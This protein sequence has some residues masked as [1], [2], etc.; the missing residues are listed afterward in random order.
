MANYYYY[1][2][3][4]FVIIPKE[5]SVNKFF[6]FNDG[7][8]IIVD[9][10]VLTNRISIRHFFENL[11]NSFQPIIQPSP[12][13]F[14]IISNNSK[15][16]I[17]QHFNSLIFNSSIWIWFIDMNGLKSDIDIIKKSIQFNI[18]N[19]SKSNAKEFIDYNLRL[20]NQNYLENSE[21]G[22]SFNVTPHIY[23]DELEKR[24]E[25]K[26]FD[27]LS[28][29]FRMVEGKKLVA[30]LKM[31]ILLID[32]KINKECKAELVREIL[33]LKFEINEDKVKEEKEFQNQVCWYTPNEQE[34]S[35]III[36]K[37]KH[38]SKN[39]THQIIKN[40]SKEK[41][42][43][44]A[45][46]SLKLAREL[47][48]DDR[49][50]F[51]LV[52]MDYLLDS[53]TKR[54]NDIDERE[55]ATEFWG[56]GSEKFFEFSEKGKNDSKYNDLIITYKK[57][58]ENRGPL[59]KLWIFPI[60]AFNQT[61]IDDLRNKGVRLIDYYWY[62]SRGA[63]PINTPYLFIYTLN[64]FLQLQLQQAVFSVNTIVKFLTKSAENVKEINNKED[65]QAFMG[66]EYSVLIQKHGW[67]P[68]IFRD[69]KA[70]S[71][72]SE[73]IWKEFYSKKENKDLFR[74]LDIVQK[75]YQ[76]CAYGEVNDVQKMRQN[77]TELKIFIIDKQTEFSISPELIDVFQDKINLIS[78]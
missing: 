22:H 75:F 52:M 63:D 14:I 15:N 20:Q 10:K 50:R 9:E 17:Y 59:H 3:G 62:L 40:L 43:I 31:R 12:L 49:V 77:W 37:V 18:S 7:N 29:F 53:K 65:F 1:C 33:E 67:R 72:F 45:V 56:D 11:N 48:S 78:T 6:S 2:S 23:S 42:Q 55:Y 46:K 25:T 32:D 51:D 39:K 13:P 64:K 69:M 36:E 34:K 24:K 60:T 76:T 74:F 57:I 5:H 28:S 47:L 44:I 8:G 73:Y 30:G 19:Y 35:P 38:Y 61:F 41:I 58:K 27:D 66:A 54:I 26:I 21:K 68:V 71:L 16:I 4:S 70:G